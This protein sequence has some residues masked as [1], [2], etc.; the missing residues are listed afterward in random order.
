MQPTCFT[1]AYLCMDGVCFFNVPP[2]SLAIQFLRSVTYSCTFYPECNAHLRLTLHLPF[3]TVSIG[4]FEYVY[5]VYT[6][7]RQ[8]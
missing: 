6:V 1:R 2:L 7:A 8:N 3:E 5:N 4:I